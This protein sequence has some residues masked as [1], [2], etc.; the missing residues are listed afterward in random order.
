MT[1][2]MDSNAHHP[3]PAPEEMVQKLPREVL[4]EGCQF[5]FRR[6]PMY[7]LT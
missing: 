5:I 7:L 3:V 2:L 1:Q 6:R 4:E